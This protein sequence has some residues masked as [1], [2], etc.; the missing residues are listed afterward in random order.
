MSVTYRRSRILDLKA[1][2]QKLEDRGHTMFHKQIQQGIA[3]VVFDPVLDSSET[4]L[5]Y[6]TAVPPDTL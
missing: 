4:I 2:C 6:E 3:F 1:A 5:R